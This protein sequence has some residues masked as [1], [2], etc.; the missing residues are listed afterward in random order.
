[1][2]KEIDEKVV[3]MR[4]DNQNFENNVKTSLST[5]DKLK[6]S[7]NLSGA[8]KG[9]ENLGTAA[10][11]VNMNALGSAVDTVHARF[12]ALEVMGVTALANITNSAV[13]A[14]KRMLRSLTIEPV[15]QGF[16][17][18]ELKM[19]SV[20]TI[21]ASTGEDIETVNGYL[22]ELN[23]YA[24]KTI[25]SFS[26]MTSNI[27]K[28]T[29][30]G[31]KLE[32]AVKAIQGISNE[33][34]VSGANAN[35]ASR[36][37]Y[38]FAQALSAGYVKLI[39]W[40][41]IETANM[42]TVEFK[43]QLLE[44]AVSLGTV[45]KSADGMYTTL[46]GNT[47]NATKNFNEVLNDQWMTTEVLVQTLGNYA[48]ETTEIG[49][50]A[51]S[52]AQ[53][54]KT[55]S[56][57]MGTL[58][59]AVGSGW[60]QTWEIVFGGFYEAKDLWT[61]ISNVV[62]GLIDRVSTFRNN[63]LE[64]A[65][66]SRFKGLSE[67]I[68]SITKPVENAI[69]KIE[70]L[71]E[72]ANRV[73]KGD[74]GNGEERRN[75]LDELYG[76][77]APIQNK[78]NEILGDSTRHAE[79]AKDAQEDLAE[80]HGKTVEELLKMT[81]AQLIALGLSEEEVASL[82]ELEN[83][84][85]KLG[86]PIEDLLKNLDKLD[87]RTLLIESFKNAWQG[88]SRILSSIKEAWVDIFPP[89]TADQLYNIILSIRSFSKHL[90][91]SLNTG[92]KIT[93][94]FKGLFAVLDI[95]RRVISEIVKTGFG[96]LSKV[97]GKVHLNVLDYTASVGD[98]L[99]KFR[100]WII[101][102]DIIAKGIQ[103][104]IGWV[105]TGID[106]VKGWVDAFLEIP[107][108]K[109]A[110]DGLSGSLRDVTDIGKNFIQ[111]F[112]NGIADGTLNIPQMLW[113]MGKKLLETL[114]SVFRMHSPSK[115]T[116]EIGLNFMKGLFNGIKIFVLT[117]IDYIKNFGKTAVSSLQNILGNVDW[118]KLFA[119]GVSVAM[120]LTVKKL[121]GVLDSL[122]SPME[123]L[124]DVFE[125]VAKVLNKSAKPIAKILKNT[126]KVVK[127]FANVLNGLAFS[128]AS[129]GVKSIAISI[130]ILVG[131][132][133]LLTKINIGDL[134]N[135]VGIVGALTGILAGLVIVVEGLT[136]LSSK[137]G[138]GSFDLAKFS[139][140]LL[141]I[142][143]ALILLAATVKI[144][145]K[146][147]SAQYQQGMEGAIG[148]I[149][150]LGTL[151][152]AYGLLTN[153][154]S[155]ENISKLGGMLLKMSLAMLI[156]VGVVKI[157]GML[158]PDEVMKGAVFGAAFLAFVGILQAITMIPGKSI[159]SLGGMLLKISL[160]MML[161]VGVVKL[162]GHL[163]ADEMKKG[164]LFAGAFLGFIAIL[165]L[166]TMIPGKKI[167]GLGKVLFAISSSMLIMAGL[168]KL[169]AT[170]EWNE[171][172]KGL[173]GIIAFTAI[174]GA[175]CGIVKMVGNDA[176]KIA[177][178]LLAMSVSIAI[179]A[180]VA[181]IL[182]LIDPMTVW[183]GVSAIVALG[184]VMSLMIY[185]TKSA[186]DCKG[187]LIAM[188]VAIGVMVAAVAVLSIID[189]LS[190]YGAVGALSIIIGMFAVVEAASSM[191]RGSMG[192][193]VVMTVA[194]GLLGGLIYLLAQLP[195]KSVIGAA[196]SL[197]IVMLSLSASCAI[198][199]LIPITAAITGAAGLATFISI[200]TGV[201]AAL[202]GLTRISGFTELIKD[203]GQT[204]SLIGYSIGNFVGS[205]IGGFGEGV[206]SG[207]PAIASNLSM[208]MVNLMPFI[209]GLQL[210]PGDLLERVGSL[211]GAILLLTGASLI[212]GITSLIS[213]GTAFTSLGDELSG[214][215][216]HAQGFIKGLDGIT[217]EKM[218]CVKLLAD[219]IL[220][221]TKAELLNGL[222]NF[223][224]LFTG[225]SSL[226]SFGKELSGLG[227]SLS[228]FIANLGTFSDDQVKTV[229]CAAD[230]LKAL[231]K[232]S[233]EIPNS[234]GLLAAIVG[235]NDL[236][237]FADQFPKLGTGLTEFLSNVGTFSDDQVKTVECAANA[238][239]LL[240]E[241]SSEIPNTGGWIAAIVGDNDLGA[242]A[243]Q[244][245]T[246]GEGLAGFV[247]N[248]GTFSDDEIKTVKCAAEAIK[249]LAEASNAIPNT[250]GWLAAIVG[251]NDLGTFAEQIP[252]VGTGINNFAKELGTFG[253]DQIATVKASVSAIMAIADLGSTN[254]SA[255]TATLPGLGDNLIEFGKDMKEFCTT[256]ADVGSTAI[257]SAVSNIDKLIDM[258]KN[259]EIVDT[260]VITSF[261]D[262]LRKLGEKGVS[263]FVD[264]FANNTAQ[265]DA[266]AAAAKLMTKIIEGIASKVRDVKDAMD[267]V[268]KNAVA[269]I[270]SDTNYQKVYNAGSYF[271][272]GFANG[273]SENAYKA[274]AKA[275]A[276]AAAAAEAAKKELK[277]HSPS[278]VGYGIGD[279]FGIGFVNAISD[280]IRSA[281]NASTE[282]AKSARNG[283]NEAI[284]KANEMIDGGMDSQPT[285]RPVLDLSNIRSG[286]GAM[287]GMLS[288]G[289]S[290][291]VLSNVGSIS[292]MMNRR[293]Q[294][295]GNTEVVSAID[296]L[297]KD[298]GN[299]QGNTYTINGI[300]YDDGSNIAEAIES[301]VRAARLGRRM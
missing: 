286:I 20:Q 36:A 28:F 186:K 289:P 113:D 60:A 265:G 210:L 167:E 205:I 47:F 193:L 160:A 100:D 158:S 197:S 132:V 19:N 249:A 55:F 86:R 209:A 9:L 6:Q 177:A 139:L 292:T 21:M 257:A 109:E 270:E 254:V 107:A 40:K 46:K 30:A 238:I 263:E 59:E 82:R 208:F 134:W 22:D 64:G 220:T 51:F 221:I 295:G 287:N 114:M 127:S 288:I 52:A 119:G 237:T 105:Q 145:G 219:A 23:K 294:N 252:K 172:G 29:N 291:E 191:V 7:L 298:L 84:S 273:I 76:D 180:G 245:P 88:L 56:Q 213:L 243:E 130:A 187:T 176:P 72:I 50:K 227:I 25:Y 214:F 102:N 99:V 280:N 165:E 200:M 34:A 63:L 173:V 83:I 170:M 258:A 196:A 144:I 8:S 161:M 166:I 279:Y 232:A 226:E 300:T 235:E 48:D 81:D 284:S 61:G 37:M 133:I 181:V 164:A 159:E 92:K 104:V 256:M 259:M 42:A 246:L 128:V 228:D 277:E 39:D 169:I 120:I 155:A 262:S 150:A 3:E 224:S 121:I 241:A 68:S 118:S 229:K 10:K 266:K 234:G 216:E 108:V 189:P 85:K 301:I 199:S 116:Y 95:V 244:F 230:A 222:S 65:L 239:K 231:A 182:G 278:R 45:T 168:C 156:M 201:L 153:G 73:I 242:F 179:L 290:V 136:I 281:Y 264:A 91:V 78:V 282:M 11:N 157:I 96:L 198:L 171:L 101:D 293:I 152:A 149:V 183:K 57:L 106:T 79:K 70:N 260:K 138:A 137:L 90:L 250:G 274:E 115:E 271:V 35:E 203:G 151:V 195:I 1:M 178:T 135:A 185:V 297:R 44:T 204:L 211:T 58:K 225:E 32:D 66:G 13:N 80:A 223:T 207:L 285:I 184:S 240:A 206:S 283:L 18:Y 233:S 147:D 112:I 103:K 77:W 269:A 117:I 215:M 267:N 98:M 31:V 74:F 141:G 175:I 276:M 110:I 129:E 146:L 17:E 15:S 142:G 268:V 194:I 251:D 212:A 190:L 75:K 217:P 69:E 93:R 163:S 41:S 162:V 126:A 67:K 87:G 89:A 123:G 143:G 4:F 124:G 248:I 236:G 53:D 27:G 122:L 125:G 272:S 43:N 154:N 33:A 188:T 62:G 174:I 24:D 94:T 14:G 97:V 255:L 26:D 148:L 140:A 71:E 296:K 38:N 299:I 275:R 192:T 253:G 247:K 261:S 49:K 16:S 218:N 5:L 12:S 2:S 54:V 202:G 111:G 131:A